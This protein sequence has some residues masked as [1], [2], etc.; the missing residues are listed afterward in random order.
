MLLVDPQA[1]SNSCVDF[2]RAEYHMLNG[3]TE[4]DTTYYIGYKVRFEAIDYQAF[5]YQWKNYDSDTVGEDNVPIV[6]TF[7]KDT[8]DDDYH[9]M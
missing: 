7:A 3:E 4:K 5:I 2:T 6:L 1:D 9:T 8:A